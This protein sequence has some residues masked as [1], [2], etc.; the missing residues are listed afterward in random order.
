[1]LTFRMR[2]SLLASGRTV[3]CS[4]ACRSKREATLLHPVLAASVSGA[5][6]AS[7]V[8]CTSHCTLRGLHVA[9]AGA[10]SRA[11]QHPLPCEI[12]GRVVVGSQEESFDSQQCIVASPHSVGVPNT[13]H[14]DAD[15]ALESDELGRS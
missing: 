9:N 11:L 7:N 8:F 6:R 1:M 12:R 13:A 10:A 5:T 14:S 4:S 15:Q 3:P 2:N